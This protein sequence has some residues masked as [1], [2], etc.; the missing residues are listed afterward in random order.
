M[1]EQILEIIQEKKNIPPLPDILHR[2][3]SKI[4]NPKSKVSDIAILIETE[5]I[6]S[7]RLIQLSNS[8]FFGGGGSKVER[9]PDA[10]IRLGLKMIL[11]LAYTLEIPKLFMHDHA[12]NQKKF[13]QHSLAVAVLS[14]LL[15]ENLTHLE[16]DPDPCYL[17][18]LMHDIG[19]VVFNFAIPK[20]YEEFLR[21]IRGL[22]KPLEVLEQ[23]RFGIAHP[24]LGALFIKKWWPIP[25][26]VVMSVEKH[27]LNMSEKG[28]K[29]PVL[30]TVIMANAIANHH[31]LEHGISAYKGALDRAFLQGCGLTPDL[32]NELV[33]KTRE[34]V[35]M[36]Q[37]VLYK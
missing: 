21:Q 9:L 35:H 15:G 37:E 17:S 19:V 1:R 13:W 5:P 23:K 16:C 31:G 22:D 7:G 28:K 33:D 25:D 3:E 24:E 36:A 12:L 34:S 29:F 6:L 26:N 32:M 14:R 2:L 4:G 27:F 8:V 18:G 20:E 11:D 30:L 10:I